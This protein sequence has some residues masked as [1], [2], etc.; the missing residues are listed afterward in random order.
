MRPRF[1]QRPVKL[2]KPGVVLRLAFD[3]HFRVRVL[4]FD[5]KEHDNADCRSDY[6]P[7]QAVHR[8][9]QCNTGYNGSSNVIWLI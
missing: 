3:K 4:L 5:R 9:N 8:E 2:F 7:E 1:V 6:Q